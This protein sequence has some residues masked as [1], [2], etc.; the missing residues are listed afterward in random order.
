M[1][2][3]TFKYDARRVG[4][5]GNSP[6]ENIYHPAEYS[7]PTKINGK[8]GAWKIVAE[9]MLNEKCVRNRRQ[10]LEATCILLVLV[11]ELHK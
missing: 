6:T 5:R 9:E 2:W 7:M 10:P 4:C 11:I 8:N 3:P 1:L